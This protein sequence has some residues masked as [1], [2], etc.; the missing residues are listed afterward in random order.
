MEA[1]GLIETHVKKVGDKLWM[2]VRDNGCGPGD[3][4]TKGYGI[5]MQNTRE[6]LAY[7]YPDAHKFDAVV[8]LTGGYEVTIQIPYERAIA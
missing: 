6:R 4:D 3:S 8:P 1:G 2:Q 5:G 7:F